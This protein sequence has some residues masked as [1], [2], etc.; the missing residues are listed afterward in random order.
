MEYPIGPGYAFT[1][2]S[3]TLTTPSADSLGEIRIVHVGRASEYR[4]A[5]DDAIVG[6]IRYRREAEEITLSSTYIDPR[7]R[8]LGIATAFIVHVLD[9]LLSEG[10]LV[11]VEC[12]IIRDFVTQH[13]EYA[14]VRV[15][16]PS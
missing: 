9:E 10:E 2:G 4:A 14:A 6:A 16:E 3:E 12:P 1:G 11:T 7:L 5:I 15:R 13:V 8:G